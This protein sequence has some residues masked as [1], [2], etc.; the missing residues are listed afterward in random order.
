M[1]ATYH[2]PITKDSLSTDP[3][4]IDKMIKKRLKIP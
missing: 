3:T 4:M 2:N 1:M